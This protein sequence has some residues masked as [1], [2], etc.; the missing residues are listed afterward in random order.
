MCV[1]SNALQSRRRGTSSAPAHGCEPARAAREARKARTG[2]GSPAGGR[3]LGG[4]DASG[5]ARS[6]RERIAPAA[7]PRT[8]GPSARRLARYG[9][10]RVEQRDTAAAPPRPGTGTPSSRRR[11]GARSGSPRTSP[12]SARG[13]RR[14]SGSRHSLTAAAAIRPS[15][16]AC[17]SGWTPSIP[18]ALQT[19]CSEPRVNWKETAWTMLAG[20]RGAAEGD[21]QRPQRPTTIPAIARRAR[22]SAAGRA[23]A[24]APGAASANGASLN[25]PAAASAPAH[26]AGRRQSSSA[27]GEHRRE[28]DVGGPASRR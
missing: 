4:T 15:T 1:G 25:H 3:A 23:A 27:N 10:G 13:R 2:I 14:A 28:H 19:D 21:E 12:P 7:A 24:R 16:A 11:A 18:S 6:C 26:A 5:L 20:A 22:A 8:R 17:A 9:D